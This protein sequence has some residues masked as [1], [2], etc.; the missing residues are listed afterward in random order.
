[1]ISFDSISPIQVT[2][3][4]KMFSHFLGQL[5]LYG[6]AGYS[7]SVLTAFTLLIKTYLR[8]GN[9]QKEEV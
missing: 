3:M 2:L 6:F 5:C 9:L 7:A 8:L 1:M 4:Q